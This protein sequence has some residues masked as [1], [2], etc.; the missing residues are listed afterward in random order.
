MKKRLEGR[1]EPVLEPE[2]Q[3]IDAHHHLIDRPS[4][5]YMV[6]DYLADAGGGHKV[7]ASVYV[8]MLTKAYLEGPEVLRPLGEVE[9]AN[10]VGA[11][12]ASGGHGICEINAAI[13]GHA[14]LRMGGQVAQLLER[15]M[16][17]APDRFRGVRQVALEHWSETP[18]RSMAHRPPSGVLNS[19]GFRPAFAELAKRNLSFDAAVY[20]IQIDELANLADAF[21]NTTIVLNHMGMAMGMEMS[22]IEQAELFIQWRRAL[23]E[24]AR[25]DNVVCKVGGLG[26]PFWGFEFEQRQDPVGYLELADRW[27]PYVETAIEAFGETRCMMESDFPMDGR[28]CGFIPLWNALKHITRACSEL[29]KAHLYRNTAARVYRID[30]ADRLAGTGRSQLPPRKG[31]G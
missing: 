25:R 16:A 29:Q 1:D 15:C 3:I 20:S 11:T 5:R 26:L 18:L 14:D 28:S 24:L 7:I 30:L 22:A 8:E 17:A 4:L 6:E 31:R 12:S 19:P 9:F 27:R 2:L 23:R 21:P 13:I 10:G